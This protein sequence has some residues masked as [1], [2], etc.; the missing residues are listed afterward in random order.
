MSHGHLPN[1]IQT[2]KESEGPLSVSG[3]WAQGRAL[4]GGL[5]AAL[6]TEG[7]AKL[8]DEPLP[9]RSF[10]G[11]FVAPAPEQGLEVD[12][13]ILRQGRAVT[14]M[15]ADVIAE[16]QVCLTSSAAFGRPRPGVHVPHQRPF[17]PAPLDSVP[18]APEDPRRPKF[19]TNFEIR[20]T[21]GG[22]PGSGSGDMTTAMWV[23]H[24]Q[25]MD[26]HPLAKIVAMADM[27][28]PVVLAHYKGLALASTLSW[29]LEFLVPPEEMDTDWFYLD[30]SLDA[31]KEGYS[32]QSGNI[33]AEDGRL[34]AVS[35]QCMVYFEQTSRQ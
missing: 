28:P 3:G 32:I 27:P 30:F 21:G 12:A 10:M 19:L 7:M 13:K 34:L 5:V 24:R 6:A 29:S 17:N 15:R 4:Y 1:I 2:F 33:F 9:I 11:S 14:Q 31:A 23:R 16:G 8:L 22:I 35:R 25:N 18:S 26:D 20:W